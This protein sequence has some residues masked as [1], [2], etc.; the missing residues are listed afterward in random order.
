M[1]K[2]ESNLR[3]IIGYENIHIHVDLIAGLPGETFDIFKESFNQAYLL[4]P[5]QLQLGFLKLLHGSKLR[6]EYA[7]HGYI[8]DETAPYE[9]ISRNS[10]SN[11]DI[12]RLHGVED[13][14][15]RIYNSGR[16]THTLKYIS[17]NSG[18]S[19]FEFYDSIAQYIEKNDT[20]KVTRSLDKYTK[21]LYD[22]IFILP[23]INR[24]VVRN[25]LVID[26]IATDNTG[27]VPQFLR[28]KDQDYKRARLAAKNMLSAGQK[29]GVAIIYGENTKY[30]IAADY[31]VRNPVT[32]R[33][34]IFRI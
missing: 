1:K 4:Y 20:S 15:E 9:I 10:I 25:L 26:R 7:E 6:R 23:N 8:F 19:P 17:K 22:Y 13:A 27:Y 28:I 30:G 16:F 11:D 24:R 31:S 12:R 33:Y 14:L 3:K 21:Y 2:L 34:K 29:I 32:K 18:L 5:H